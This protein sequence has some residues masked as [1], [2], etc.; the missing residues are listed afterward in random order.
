M[1]ENLALF[2]LLF[3][4]RMVAWVLSPIRPSK[5]FIVTRFS[6]GFWWN[7]PFSAGLLLWAFAAVAGSLPTYAGAVS[8]RREISFKITPLNP[9]FDPSAYACVHGLGLDGQAGF[10]G[11][12]ALSAG[13]QAAV[14]AALGL[15]VEGMDR[16]DRDL[17]FSRA[18]NGSL[19]KFASEYSRF[20]KAQLDSLGQVVRLK[21]SEFC[22]AREESV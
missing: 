21:L 17:L 10:H 12:I 20:T 8:S 11:V 2:R 16:L 3:S 7:R 22:K 6:D 18:L 19:P 5:H 9:A 1:C 15:S 4:E 13:F 14:V